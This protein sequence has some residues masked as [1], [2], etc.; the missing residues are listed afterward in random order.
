[1]DEGGTTTCI[2][3]VQGK[4]VLGQIDS[5][6]DNGRGRL[7]SEGCSLKRR[8]SMLPARVGRRFGSNHS[9]AARAGDRP[10]IR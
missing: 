6:I 3:A 7:Q 1:V 5:C 10:F 9:Q 2:D 8:T 4:H